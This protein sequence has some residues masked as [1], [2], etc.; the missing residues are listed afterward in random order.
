M[1]GRDGTGPLGQGPMTGRAMGDCIGYVPPVYGTYSPINPN[2]HVAPYSGY[3]YMSYVAPYAYG[4]RNPYGVPSRFGW[5]GGRGFRGGRGR[6][7]GR[8]WR[9]APHV[10]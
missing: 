8:S 2:P 9:F 1:P 3:S 6:G 7:M 4:F 10:W 5:W